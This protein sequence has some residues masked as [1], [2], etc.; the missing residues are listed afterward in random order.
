MMRRLP[1]V[2]RVLLARLPAISVSHVLATVL[3]V[4]I[5]GAAV[6][7]SIPASNGVITGCY[8][9]SGGAL[10]IIDTALESCT[11]NNELSVNWNQV[12]PRGPAGPQGAMG[13]PGP[14]GIPAVRASRRDS[15]REWYRSITRSSNPDAQGVFVA[16]RS[17]GTRA[18]SSP[19]ATS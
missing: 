11:S 19:R 1:I 3:A 12:G 16:V 13:T 5:A 2:R 18:I 17:G 14:Q 8:K 9:K 10:R 7:G 4:L 15:S 6:Y